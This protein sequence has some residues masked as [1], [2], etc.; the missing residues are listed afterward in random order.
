[1]VVFHNKAVGDTWWSIRQGEDMF[2]GKSPFVERWSWSAEGAYYPNHEVLFELISYVFWKAS[3][4]S[5]FLLYMVQAALIV[6]VFYWARPTANLMRERGLNWGV[7]S[8]TFI[9]CLPFL[10]AARY[11]FWEARAQIFTFA[12]FAL[13]LHLLKREKYWPI[14]LMFV[15]WVNLHGAFLAG[16]VLLFGVWLLALGRW[17][18]N[19]SPED[20]SRV[21]GIGLVGALSLAG[22]FASGLHYKLWVYVLSN[23][24]KTNSIVVE[25]QHAWEDPDALRSF[26]LVIALLALTAFLGGRRL[27]KGWEMQ[28]HLVGLLIFLPLAA[29]ILRFIPFAFIALLPLLTV[30]LMEPRGGRLGALQ[31]LSQETYGKAQSLPR[32]ALAPLLALTIA[33]GS[34][35]A[36]Q[37]VKADNREMVPPSAAAAL[38]AHCPDRVYNDYPSGAFLLWGAKDHKIYVDNRY[39]PY[40]DRVKTMLEFSEYTPWRDFLRKEPISCV[41]AD[42]FDETDI[43]LHDEKWPILWE[44]DFWVLFKNPA[45]LSKTN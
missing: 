35:G 39:D 41:F 10:Y 18:K 6:G 20:R 45:Y 28:I 5:N 16:G 13:L 19:R 7:V 27:L 42:R 37:W 21:L 3:F 1:M 17:L 30:A 14:P 25:F 4:D 34:V 43:L 8:S 36:L 44:N 23:F 12:L 2:Q 38:A 32:L 31:R 33:L 40:P 15:L 26:L 29:W 24:G 11:Y 22:T 9:L